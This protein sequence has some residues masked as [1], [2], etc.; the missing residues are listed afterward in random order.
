M[1]P[2]ARRPHVLVNALSLIQGGGRTYV[3]NLLRELERDSRGF[4][5]TI[6]TA[7][8]RLSREEAG[9]ARL[10]TVRLPGGGS[11]VTTLARVLFEEVLLP[12]RARSFDLLYC[13]ADV[14]PAWGRT[15]TVVA[16]RNL[17]I[18]DRRF[19]DS[20]RLRTLERLARL[21]TR[22]AARVLF[23]SQAAAHFISARLRIP[24]D[25]YIVVPHG[26]STELFAPEGTRV[27][28]ERP[29][30]LAPCAPE[31]HKNLGVAIQG[32]AVLSR[33]DVELWI[34]GA[35]GTNPEH[36]AELEALA[37]ELGIA[38]RVRFLGA[39]PYREIAAHYRGAAALLFPSRLETFGH[40]L[41]E[42]MLV[43]TPVLASDLPVF[44][45]VAGAAALYFHPER[46]AELAQRTEELL[47]D[48][49][50]TARRVALGA[51]R[52][53]AF[54]WRRSVDLLCAVFD[55]VLNEHA[56][57]PARGHQPVA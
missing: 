50:A 54:S 10:E 49:A 1:K 19:D 9:A 36:R 45:E 30:L 38:E 46:P 17:N 4:E 39:V 53:R 34:A 24:A 56:R 28:S 8:G 31:P 25:R 2:A 27:H 51:E 23:P 32:L 33:Q 18:Y 5:F 15:P 22:R 26:I 3:V 37:R 35:S 48:G 43:G 47:R 29:Y 11:F 41:L 57:W 44:H 6:L 7:E 20:A 12:A 13:V 55:E 52:A 40:P 14:S 21:G 16:L 42:S